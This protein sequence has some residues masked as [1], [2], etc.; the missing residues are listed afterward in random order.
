MA[1]GTTEFC[2]CIG[3]PSCGVIHDDVKPYE[4]T[5]HDGTVERVRYCDDCASL[6]GGD[7]NGETAAIKPVET[8]P[9]DYYADKELDARR[10]AAQLDQA[11]DRGADRKEMRKLEEALELARYVGD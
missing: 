5:H 11:R 7:W 10:A 6:A 9:G 1:N 8:N 2:G 4:V 3:C